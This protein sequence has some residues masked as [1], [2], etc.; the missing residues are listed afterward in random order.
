MILAVDE[1]KDMEIGK[2]GF[3]INSTVSINKLFL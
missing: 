2:L 3:R 1:E